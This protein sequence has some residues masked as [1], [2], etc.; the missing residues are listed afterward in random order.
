[1]ITQRVTL[2]TEC[3][4]EDGAG[5]RTL[6]KSNSRARHLSRLNGC[7]VLY[8]LWASSFWSR[9]CVSETQVASLTP[10]MCTGKKDLQNQV[11]QV[12][13]QWL[14]REEYQECVASQNH[15]II[16]VGKDF[17]GNLA[18]SFPKKLRQA[19]SEAHILLRKK[20]MHIPLSGSPLYVMIYQP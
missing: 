9:R 7:N 8:L 16:K 20:A 4:L 19:H 5:K 18:P 12:A 1:M 13:A 10:P 17:L 3:C 11:L 2:E 14:T 15:R 6:Y